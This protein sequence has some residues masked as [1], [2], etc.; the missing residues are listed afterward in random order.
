MSSSIR[1]LFEFSRRIA[2]GETVSEIPLK[3]GDE[4]G[5]LARHM[6]RMSVKFG[7]Q[8][9]L[10]ASER[11]HLT[12][13][14]NSMTEGVLVTDGGGRIVVVNPALRV[15]LGLVVDPRGKTPLE[16][17]RNV[18]VSQGVQEI[19]KKGS[20]RELEFVIANRTLLARFAPIRGHDHIA[21][22]VVVFHDITELRRLENLQKEF[23]SNVSH[24]LKTP[25]TSI[26]GYAE[27]LLAEDELNPVYQ[28]FAE[29]IFRNSSQLSQM[30]EELF[31][32]AR[33]ESGEP[34]IIW[35]VVS[36]SEL[37]ERIS[38]DFSEQLKSKDLYFEYSNS[39]DNDTFAAGVRYVERV[40]SNLIENA[41]KYTENG[42]IKVT[43]DLVEDEVVFCVRDTGIGI[44]EDE[45]ESI[46]RR[47]YRVDKDRSRQTGGSGIGLAIV[48]HIVQLHG[49]RV[50][51]ESV[52]GRGSSFYF[53]LPRRSGP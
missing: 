31:S 14:L 28:G 6:E 15:I 42:E 5:E 45:L 18:E 13:I 41:I 20:K 21:G 44:P 34:T 32:L 52:V 50:W 9:S 11:N 1:K 2:D 47:F 49:G 48:K 17:I 51:A 8:L 37:M 35:Q 3:S 43:M 36:Y 4:L 38:V 53:T 40:F 19:L 23:V 16:V 33:L 25:L 10:L 39:T 27:T 22:V 24:E 26:Q 30:I 12:T 29:K 7:E 46:F